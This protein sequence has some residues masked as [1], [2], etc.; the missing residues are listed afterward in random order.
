MGLTFDEGE[1]GHGLKE[2]YLAKLGIQKCC[3][4][5]CT[6]KLKEMSFVGIC[7]P[8]QRILGAKSERSVAD[9]GEF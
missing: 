5:F 4:T 1:M 8:A 2:K 7:Y 9:N 6:D 3:S